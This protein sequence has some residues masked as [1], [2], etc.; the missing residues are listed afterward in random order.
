MGKDLYEVLGV[1]RDATSSD[2]KKAYMKLARKHHPDKGGD[3]GKFQE[4][5]KAYEVLS[6]ENKKDKYDKFGEQGLEGSGPGID[7]TELFASM[8]SGGSPF[9]M[10]FGGGGMFNF[11][12]MQPGARV[13]IN[14]REFTIGRDGR[15][16]RKA[17]DIIKHIY[18]TLKDLYDGK[19]VKVDKYMVT[20][21]KGT[22][23]GKE[24]TIP[25]KGETENGKEPGDLK[26]YILQK[27]D[28]P[29]KSVYTMDENQNLIIKK[30]ISIIESMTGFDMKIPHPQG[31]DLL[32]KIRDIIKYDEPR[33][34]IEG[35]GMPKDGGDRYGDLI[36]LFNIHY[37]NIKSVMP[38]MRKLMPFQEIEEDETNERVEVLTYRRP[39]MRTSRRQED[40]PGDC[41]AQ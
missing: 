33:R 8:F 34:Y 18:V 1:T 20:I 38:L 26:F 29:L 23:F 24:F 14:G 5:S 15:P 19:K 9:G 6:D 12:G 36:L 7:P 11:A 28:D 3:K 13:N 10:R 16:I 35:K 25:G 37:N 40:K 30:D 2:I 39:R 4:I 41:N 22:H 17:K 32:I 27:Q 21:N 31:K